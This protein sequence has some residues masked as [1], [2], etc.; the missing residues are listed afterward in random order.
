MKIVRLIQMRKD[1]ENLIA[2]GADVNEKA[3]KGTP[4]EH[5]QRTRNPELVQILTAAGAK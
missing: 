3:K 5:A 1:I 4:L 2:N